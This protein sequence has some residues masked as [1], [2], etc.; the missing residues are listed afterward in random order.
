[1][2]NQ[3]LKNRITESRLTPLELRVVVGAES[4]SSFWWK[5]MWKLN[6]PTS[7]DNSLEKWKIKI[8]SAWQ[9]FGENE[10]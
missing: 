8:E 3:K 1:M 7:Q 4:K 5:H 10:R 2:A 9:L 6:L